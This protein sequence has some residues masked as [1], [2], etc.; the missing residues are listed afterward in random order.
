MPKKPSPDN[1]FSQWHRQFS[2]EAAAD[3]YAEILRHIEYLELDCTP[4]DML[5]DTTLLL[6]AVLAY[7]QMDGK[8]CSSL[9]QLQRYRLTSEDPPFYCLTFK[10][11]RGHYGRI[12]TD[13]AL[14]QV[15]F[16]DLFDHPWYKY[17]TA[18]FHEVFISRLDGEAIGKAELKVLYRRFTTDLYFDYTEDEVAAD[19][20][21]TEL[22]DTVLATAVDI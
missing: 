12:L 14:S 20:H 3:G 21:M 8:N 15:D 4:E 16:A 17:K 7:A 9:V 10:L 19:V 13:K 11:C 22:E 18:G 1:L 5:T 2:A 6:A